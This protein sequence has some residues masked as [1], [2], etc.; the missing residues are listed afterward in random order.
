MRPSML[1]ALM[2]VVCWSTPCAIAVSQTGCVSIS[3]TDDAI[4]KDHAVE[5][6]LKSLRVEID[7]WK[8]DNSVTGPVTEA[9]ENGAEPTTHSSV[10][11]HDPRGPGRR[12]VQPRQIG[13]RRERGQALHLVQDHVPRRPFS[14][15]PPRATSCK[16]AA[17]LGWGR[18]STL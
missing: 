2:T 18:S 10:V 5:K 3:A 12:V 17:H 16:N 4:D 6:S 13:G 7:K 11:G 14:G 15:H 1:L 8:A 9:A